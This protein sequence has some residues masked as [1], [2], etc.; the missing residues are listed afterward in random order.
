MLSAILDN[1]I[2]FSPRGGA[3]TLR[4]RAE[5]R[6]A[7]IEVVD[8][9]AGIAA[10]DLPFVAEPFFQGRHV[11]G[12]HGLGLAIAHAI[13]ERRGGQMSIASAPGH[14]TTV[15]LVLPLYGRSGPSLLARVMR[16]N[17]AAT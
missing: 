3:V 15:R 16:H 2:K 12:G 5:R 8:Q 14:G 4:A 7:V 17:R 6:R 13:A 9:G 10:A 1:A 11:Q